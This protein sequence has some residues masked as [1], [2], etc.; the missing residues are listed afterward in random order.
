MLGE[1]RGDPNAA[2]LRRGEFFEPRGDTRVAVLRRRTDFPET[3]EAAL[4]AFDADPSPRTFSPFLRAYA[5][6]FTGGDG[7]AAIVEMGEAANAEALSASAQLFVTAI[8]QALSHLDRLDVERGRIHRELDRG[9]WSPSE[10]QRAFERMNARIAPQVMNLYVARMVL[11]SYDE[12]LFKPQE[13]QS[14]ARAFAELYDRWGAELLRFGDPARELVAHQFAQAARLYREAG[15]SRAST[16]QTSAI[17]NWRLAAGSAL[18]RG[19]WERAARGYAA[20]A[21]LY[22]EMYRGES[23]PAKQKGWLAQA[24]VAQRLIAEISTFQE[25]VLPLADPIRE[26]LQRVDLDETNDRMVAGLRASYDANNQRTLNVLRGE[27]ALREGRPQDAIELFREAIARFQ[28]SATEGNPPQPWIVSAVGYDADSFRYNPYFHRALRGLLAAYNAQAA[29]LMASG[30]ADAARGL[31]E[32]AFDFFLVQ[33]LS[34]HAV[35]LALDLALQAEARGE[36]HEAAPWHFLL[37]QLFEIRLQALPLELRQEMEGPMSPWRFWT[38]ENGIHAIDD[39]EEGSESF[40]RFQRT[41]ALL[42]LNRTPVDTLAA[43]VAA[44]RSTAGP[45]FLPVMAAAQNLAV[46]ADGIQATRGQ[47]K[48][49]AFRSNCYA[50]WEAYRALIV[51]SQPEW[52]RDTSLQGAMLLLAERGRS[53]SLVPDFFPDPKRGD[54]AIPIPS[55]PF[56]LPREFWTLTAG[57]MSEL[58]FREWNRRRAAGEPEILSVHD[59]VRL[60]PLLEFYGD[61][62]N[63]LQQLYLSLAESL[64]RLVQ[65][66]GQEMEAALGFIERAAFYWRK[67]GQEEHANQVELFAGGI[68]AAAALG[69]MRPIAIAPAMSPP[70][71]VARA[72]IEAQ[73]QKISDAQIREDA[74]RAL[75]EFAPGQ[76]MIDFDA[77]IAGER[78]KPDDPAWQCVAAAALSVQERP[79]AIELLRR[80]AEAQGQ[81]PHFHPAVQAFMAELA[82]SADAPLQNPSSSGASHSDRQDERDPKDPPGRRGNSGRR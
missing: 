14:F 72:Q 40:Q 38:A 57:H 23:N 82:R 69:Q 34:G 35:T 10:D 59:L 25:N 50:F 71:Y 81:L 80:A 41:I 27:V 11:V 65:E 16:T 17:F 20:L 15:D 31:L 62:R 12:I 21:A 48:S 39:N 66:P 32:G 3:V 4:A 18:D 37:N 75:R 76:D 79:E 2:L 52:Y 54:G 8:T 51:L 53:G 5:E 68:R 30:E 74:L 47:P 67:A 26:Q 24:M 1:M 58:T 46:L 63:S 36:A 49:A 73:L 19:E 64:G 6:A 7:R 55:L 61:P 70:D 13:R 77:V 56:S 9:I 43:Q 42:F 22:L 45:R 29:S 44:L 78:E 28:E 60:E 33:R